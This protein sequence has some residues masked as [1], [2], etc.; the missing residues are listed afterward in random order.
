MTGNEQYDFAFVQYMHAVKHSKKLITAHN[1]SNSDLERILILCIIFTCYE[2]LAGNYIAAKMH[3]RNGLRILQQHSVTLRTQPAHE[4][5]E[6]VLHRFDFQAMTFSE[7]SS[8]YVYDSKDIPDIDLQVGPY[9]NN[10][11]ARN[12][13]VKLL[14]GT[15]WIAGVAE[16]DQRAPQNPDW[17]YIRGKLRE[18]LTMWEMK[19]D[20]YC[21]SMDKESRSDPKTHAGNI[22]LK[23]YILATRTIAAAGAGV[24]SEM[25]W[26]EYIES[27]RTLVDLAETLPVL[28]PRSPN[29]R[30]SPP[31]HTPQPAGSRI[32][33]SNGR[34]CCFTSPFG[35]Q[36]ISFR[37]ERTEQVVPSALQNS[38]DA[39]S[40]PTPVAFSPSFELSPIV[41]L[42]ITISRCR[43]PIIRRR[44]LRLLLNYRRREGVWDSLGAGLVAVEIIK[45]EEGL[46]GAQI[47]PKNWLPLNPVCKGPKDVLEADRVKDLFI[48][49]DIGKGFVDLTFAMTN[50]EKWSEKRSLRDIPAVVHGGK[51]EWT[52]PPMKEQSV[53]LPVSLAAIPRFK[54]TS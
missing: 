7:N 21:D 37:T 40:D 5:I 23:I 39:D 53:D 3:L 31:K 28:Q 9:T 51:G 18:A 33:V 48:G 47:G 32:L 12:D 44:A 17:L 54:Y 50:G 42:F 45:R 2:N 30:P 20:E 10:A 49:V 46:R 24:T 25:A 29:S 22:L 6:D 4:A 41:P 43:D 34:N 35:G 13:L 11:A 19:F 15:M 16:A 52:C 38:L 14:R 36:K 27:F 26:D 8:P 1:G